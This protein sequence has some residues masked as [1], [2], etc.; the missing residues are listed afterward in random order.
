MLARGELAEAAAIAGAERIVA[1]GRGL[2]TAENLNLVHDLAD[3]LDAAI[4]VSL[5]VVDAGWAPR[6]MQVGQTGTVVS[7][8]L[9]VACGISGQI[10]HRIGIESSHT[11]IAIHTDRSAPITGFCDMAVVGDLTVL[12]P[13]LTAM[14]RRYRHG[15]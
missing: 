8:R 15:R 2:G 14:I 3:A 12:L 6:S 9:Y 13:Q 10:Q 4:G 5:P 11:I 1:G 7:P